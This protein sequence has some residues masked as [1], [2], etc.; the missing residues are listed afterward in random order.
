METIY[1]TLP[2][3]QFI[4]SFA[5]RKNTPGYDESRKYKI[6]ECNRD[7]V[8]T[9]EFQ[10]GLIKSVLT[11]AP[12]PTIAICDNQ[13]VDGGN[14]STTLHQFVNNQFKVTL[15]DVEY[16]YDGVR[17]NPELNNKWLSCQVNL[18]VTSNATEDQFAELYENLNKG[19]SLTHGQKLVNRDHYP[20]VLMALAMIGRT[21]EVEFPLAALLSRVWKDSFKTT[22]TR[23]EVT[24]AFQILA[25]AL[26][27]PDNFH[28]K[29]QYHIK[30]IKS[31]TTDQINENMGNLTRILTMIDNVDPDNTILRK[32]KIDIFK[33][34]IGGIIYDSRN[35]GAIDFQTKWNQ[36]LR[37]A[38]TKLTRDQ[39]KQLVDVGTLRAKAE[40]RI[41]G[42]SDNVRMYNAGEF[43]FDDDARATVETEIDDQSEE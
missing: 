17:A 41:K 1:I 23:S 4:T 43:V 24:L 40:S 27:G 6:A 33:R 36:F 38:Y 42:L 16:D 14:R 21:R 25:S 3:L 26:F 35:M 11:G 29:F 28:M 8:W 39:L 10:Q 7:F 22:K 9:S 2:L 30:L 37:D 31:V 18:M 32:T 15:G 34:F 5:G 20:L 12:I 19:M 13:I